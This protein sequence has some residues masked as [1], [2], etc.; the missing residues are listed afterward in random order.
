MNVRLALLAAL[1]AFAAA[2]LPLPAQDPPAE[3]DPKEK[4][5]KMREEEAGSL[6]EKSKKL[7]EEGKFQEAQDQLKTLRSRY[8]TTQA[9]LE[10]SEAIDSM[11]SDCGFKVAAAGMASIKINKKQAHIDTLLGF[12]FNPPEGWR[13]IPNWQKLFGQ[14]DTSEADWRGET[15]RVTRYTSRWLESLHLK[16]YKTYAPNS[17]EEVVEGEEKSWSRYPFE[18]MSEVSSED[19]PTPLHKNV[20]RTIKKDNDGNRIVNYAFLENRK[21]FGLT[22]YWRTTEDEFVWFRRSGDK[23][24]RGPTDEEWSAALK[25]FDQVA[26]SFQIMSQ[27]QLAQMRATAKGWGISSDGWCVRCVD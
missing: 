1:F 3:E 25:V 5:R 18:G 16:A 6:F 7:F 26:K 2:P 14:A 24:K 20:K 12:Q 10:N 22:G 27:P 11:I 8:F 13:G 23:K 21:G 4:K 15:Y 19:W 17:I 9:F